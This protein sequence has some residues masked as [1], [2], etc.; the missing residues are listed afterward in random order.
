MAKSNRC[1]LCGGALKKG[2]CVECGLDND[3]MT[4]RTYRLNE[5]T[6]IHIKRKQIE[7]QQ[8]EQ[9]DYANEYKQ[10]QDSME[11]MGSDQDQR[12]NQR[13]NV[14]QQRR[15]VEQQ[16][17]NIGQSQTTTVKQ[18][19]KNAWTQKTRERQQQVQQAG[20]STKGSK[21]GKIIVIFYVIVIILSMAGGLIGN[22]FDRFP[23]GSYE[24]AVEPEPVSVSEEIPS[25]YIEDDSYSY[26]M[27][28]LSQ[29]GDIFDEYLTQGNYQVGVH[30]PE[31]TYD[32]NLIDGDYGSIWLKDVENVI[33]LSFSIGEDADYQYLE[34]VRLYEGA[35]LQ[36]T[37]NVE[38]QFIADNAQEWI[39]AD[40]SEDSGLGTIRATYL[41]DEGD[42]IAGEAIPAGIYN[43]EVIDGWATLTTFYQDENGNTISNSFW[44]SDGVYESVYK[45][46]PIL[47]G[48]DISVEY[49]EV[50]LVSSAWGTADDAEA[51]F[52]KINY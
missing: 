5:T 34:N 41:I 38:L 15:S 47:E 8:S 4:K 32:I 24:F 37:G 18:D 20:K 1:Y 52:E 43:L 25:P 2:R 27:Y 45:N 13:R 31:G 26:A 16:R 30:I 28:E 49:G 14:E 11:R 33:Y 7:A 40:V 6:P 12:R 17:R 50:Q 29:E 19:L 36:I 39:A 3:R 46:V 48:M 35:Y 51:L 44:L 10:K 23:S 21:I 9:N 22:L 42:T